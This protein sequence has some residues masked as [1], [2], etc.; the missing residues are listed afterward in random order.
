MHGPT[1][2]PPDADGVETLVANH[3]PFLA[4]AQRRVGDRALAEDIL[5]DAFVP[6]IKKFD[7]VRGG[8]RRLV[9]RLPGA[10]RLGMRLSIGERGRLLRLGCRCA[11]R[12][13]PGPGVRLR[14]AARL[15]DSGSQGRAVRAAVEVRG[16]D[17]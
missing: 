1:E 10:L 16:G 13:R 2:A 12:S 17:E 6:D 11:A 5:Q 14:E 3:R 7:A 15:A 9:R 8:E 4:F